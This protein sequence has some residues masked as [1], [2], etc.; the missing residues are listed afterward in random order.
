MND[1]EYASE[2]IFTISRLLSGTLVIVWIVIAYRIGGL[3]LAMR[4]FLL[5]MIPLTFV[6]IP[7]L[8][9]RIAGIAT[10]ESLAP[11]TSVGPAVLRFTGWSVLLGVPLAW[12][13]FSWI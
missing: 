11:D 12:R 2:R 9:S 10:R 4:A 6:W 8:M 7:E 5:F 1:G 13:V 3:N